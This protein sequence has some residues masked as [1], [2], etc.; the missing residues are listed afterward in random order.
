MGGTSLALVALVA[1]TLLAEAE[2][3]RQE[4]K[5]GRVLRAR[6]ICRGSRRR[7]EGDRKRCPLRV[8]RKLCLL[9]H[10]FG[11]SDQKGVSKPSF[12]AVHLRRRETTVAVVRLCFDLAP[13]NGGQNRWNMSNPR[14][15]RDRQTP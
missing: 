14:L 10:L 8:G 15:H 3:D 4:V 13:K 2:E 5:Q 1:F 6:W 9:A 12:A 11:A 7:L